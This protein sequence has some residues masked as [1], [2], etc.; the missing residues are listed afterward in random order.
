M[1]Q[2]FLM[3]DIRV[4]TPD[5]LQKDRSLLIEDGRISEIAGSSDTLRKT[6]EVGFSFKKCTALPG[7]INIHDHL[8]GTWAPKAGEGI[9]A[10]VY[11]WLEYYE[12]HPVRLERMGV[13]D[14]QVVALGGYRNLV[15]GVTSV[16]DHYF[17][18][19]KQTYEGSPI[20][21]ITAFGREWVIA[22]ATN[23]AEWTSWGEGISEEIAKTEG[24]AP[25]VIHISE[26][27]D[28]TAKAELGKLV[29][30]GGLK[31]N[32]V[33]IH[34]IA[35]S[36]EDIEA[37]RKVGAKIVWC[38]SSN[39][40][41]YGDTLDVRRALEAGVNVSLGT[42]ST[43]TGS[44]NLLKEM[45]YARKAYL[46][47]HSRDLDPEVLFRMVTMNPAKALMMDSMIGSIEKGKSA[48]V[49]VIEDGGTNPYETL[50]TMDPPDLDLVVHR[51]TPAFG[52]PKYRGL[53]EKLSSKFTEIEIQG[54]RM[55]VTGD[56]EG[57]LRDIFAK[58]GY[59]KKFEF[60]DIKVA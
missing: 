45:R 39:H 28:S 12:R 24:K 38:P 9:Y 33:L 6:P 55:L 15:S 53:F 34:C 14:V 36:R 3:N 1:T 29:S 26:G 7:L 2:S 20:R 11:Q 50:L 42:D 30:L 31:A 44:E 51:G 23:P 18:L 40:F 5:G 58:L 60:F 10:N 32:T 59:R 13:P 37:V 52:K 46:E 21:V 43:V 35:F 47:K 25:F 49:L 19:P 54:R 8:I 56:P 57:L 41:L 22:S 16:V 27:T 17:R 48:D 4:S